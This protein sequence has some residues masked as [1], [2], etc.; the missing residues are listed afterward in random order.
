MS[1]ERDRYPDD[2]EEISR[3]IRFERAKGRCEQCGLAHG[4]LIVRSEK[5]GSRYLLVDERTMYHYGED[6]LPIRLSEIPDEFEALKYTRVVLTVHHVGAPKP[7]GSPGDRHDKMDC[8]D[9]NLAALC[10]RCHW[11][12]DI[13][14]HIEKSKEAK[15]RKKQERRRAEGQLMLPGIEAL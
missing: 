6:G 7:D 5:D 12:A 1:M 8:R 2:W 15:A 3:R 10:Q 13:D 4:A 14:I 9:E 11:L